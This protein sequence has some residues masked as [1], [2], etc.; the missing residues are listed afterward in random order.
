M[1]KKVELE[2]TMVGRRQ[3]QELDREGVDISQYIARSEM[4]DYW[5]WG[6]RVSTNEAGGN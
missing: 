6:E 3:E 5:S 2:V 1:V 4:K